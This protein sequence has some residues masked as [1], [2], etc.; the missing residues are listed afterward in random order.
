MKENIIIYDGECGFCNRFIL[1]IAKNDTENTFKF[2][3]NDSNLAK[4]IFSKKNI[5][6]KFSEETIFLRTEKTIYTKGKAIKEIFKRIPKYKYLYFLLMFAN[7][8][9][10][11]LGYTSFSRIRKKIQPNNCE[12]PSK[13]IIAK[14]ILN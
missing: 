8:H 12:I 10:I 1:F 4:S 14:F 2:T 13:K 11:D 5:N 9:I 3:P 6:T 7:R